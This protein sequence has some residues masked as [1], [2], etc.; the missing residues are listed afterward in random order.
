ME[1]SMKNLCKLF[2]VAA[3]GGGVFFTMAQE[4]PGTYVKN[5]PIWSKK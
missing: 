3:F 5:G 1:G 4:A 2:F